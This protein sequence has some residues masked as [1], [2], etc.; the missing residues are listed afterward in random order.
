[1]AIRTNVNRE[2]LFVTGGSDIRKGKT[3][4]TNNNKISIIPENRRNEIKKLIKRN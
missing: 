1:M 3:L 4:I 2:K